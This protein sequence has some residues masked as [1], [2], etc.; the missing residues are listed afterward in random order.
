[1]EPKNIFEQ[2]LLGQKIINDNIAQI[3][4]NLKAIAEAMKSMQTIYSEPDATGAEATTASTS[5]SPKS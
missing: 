2:I 3:G 5:K 1:M 4:E